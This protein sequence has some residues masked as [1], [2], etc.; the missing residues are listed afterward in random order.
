MRRKKPA[1]K[2]PT[3]QTFSR[4]GVRMVQRPKTR[5]CVHLET[6]CRRRGLSLVETVITITILTS[7]TLGTTLILVPVA[8]QSRIQRETTI[9]NVEAR[10]ILE[11]LH[12]IPFGDI[13]T[14][15]PDETD[16]ELDNLPG[17]RLLVSYVDPAADPL[18][19]HVDLKWTSPDLGSVTVTFVTVRTE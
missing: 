2:T 9:A 4:Q 18:E 17:G 1:P 19:I 15:Y 7:V 16:I 10:R 6:P 3:E 14:T 8:R 5:R 12:A 11:R 13:V